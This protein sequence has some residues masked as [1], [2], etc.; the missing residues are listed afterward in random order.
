[1]TVAQRWIK[2]RV[3]H[4]E[5]YSK[6]DAQYRKENKHKIRRRASRWNQENKN[7]RNETRRLRYQMLKELL[8]NETHK[9]SKPSNSKRQGKRV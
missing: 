6:L 1:M 8:H 7:K 9:T 3:L 5:L 2:L 4:P